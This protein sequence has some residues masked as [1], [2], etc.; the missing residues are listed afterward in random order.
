MET[1][2]PHSSETAGYHL[3]LMPRG[4]GAIELQALILTLSEEYGGPV[5]L[6]HVTLLAR[7]PESDENVVL[8][9]THILASDMEHIS[10]SLGELESQDSYFKALYLV[11]RDQKEMRALHERASLLFSRQ[12]DVSYQAHLSLLYGNYPEERKAQTRAELNVPEIS[13]V[14]DAIHVYR[15]PGSVDTWQKIGEF[16]FT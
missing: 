13:F 11:V 4:E 10:L 6:P 8:E 3:F 14:A 9:K 2:D 5:F 16:A 12:P 15:T 1:F 7:I